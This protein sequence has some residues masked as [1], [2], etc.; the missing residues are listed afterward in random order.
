VA[1]PVLPGSYPRTGQVYGQEPGKSGEARPRKYTAHRARSRRNYRHDG[2]WADPDPD[3]R[4][5]KHAA[6][7]PARRQRLSSEQSASQAAARGRLSQLPYVVL[8]AGVGFGVLYMQTG[9]DVQSGTLVLAG[10][11]LLAA[12]ARLTLPEQR[13][14]MLAARTRLPDVAALA[15][16]GL[17]LL[18][19]GLVMPT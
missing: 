8:L 14:G 16:L 19:T 18:V 12:L 15:A 4:A 17:G 6:R 10:V 7:S 3:R 1:S 2:A 5:L 13:I 9:H 11:L